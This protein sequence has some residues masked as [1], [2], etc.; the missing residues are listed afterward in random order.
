MEKKTFFSTEIE[1]VKLDKCDIVA[2]SPCPDDFLSCPTDFSEIG[3]DC[4]ENT[5]TEDF[6]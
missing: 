1:I 2:A 6:G 5:C 3:G 4:T